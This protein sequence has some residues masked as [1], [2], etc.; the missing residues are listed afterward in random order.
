[1][2]DRLT[3]TI[4]TFFKKELGTKF[5]KEIIDKFA[6]YLLSS[7][8]VYNGY[9][10][11]NQYDCKAVTGEYPNGFMIRTKGDTE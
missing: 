6:D 11:Y 3:K 10:W 8:E 4:D 1:M 5:N 9:Y 2:R 7:V